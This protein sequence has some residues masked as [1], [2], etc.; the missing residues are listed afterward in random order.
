LK[1]YCRW[2][3]A[4]LKG[5]FPG[6][7]EYSRLRRL[8]NQAQEYLVVVFQRLSNTDSFGLVADGTPVS[9]METVRGPYAHSFRNP[10]KGKSA[11]KRQW[12][13]GFILELVIEQQG[14]IAFFSV[15]VEAEIR[16][17]ESILEDLADRWILGDRGNRSQKLHER[18]WDEKQ[19]R[20]KLTGGKDRQW[21]ENVMGTLK[22]R[23]GLG[24]IRKI[25][26]MPSFLA[27][28]K[29]IL[30]AYNIATALHLSI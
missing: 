6:L 5:L 25:R 26:K 13:W 14:L 21:I 20:I 9:V 12:Y 27:R 2:L 15:G 17:L 24:R 7:V 8:F 1:G 3:E 23:L 4:N 22:D 19:I 28:L 29:A 11:T 16:Q 18:L 30:C 10:R